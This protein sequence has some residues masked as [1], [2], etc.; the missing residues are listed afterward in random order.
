MRIRGSILAAVL[1]LSACESRESTPT[2]T[3][4]PPA[5]FATG[6]RPD[7]LFL[8]LGCPTCHAKGA[9]YEEKIRQAKGKS[10]E[11]VSAWILD[12]QKKKPGTP[13]PT[14][15]SQLSESQARALATWVLGELESG[16]L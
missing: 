1:V 7:Q 5:T 8:L 2:A 4:L 6:P 9:P 10:V 3:P 12:P 11:E 13:M 15:S 16:R 14:F